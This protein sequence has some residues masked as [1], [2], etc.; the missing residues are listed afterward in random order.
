ML[1]S[2]KGVAIGLVLCVVAAAATARADDPAAA[3]ALFNEGKA[4]AAAGR[5]G[6]ACPR[7]E[8]SQRMAP[9]IGTRFNLADCQEHIG[10]TA[11]A[12][13]NFLGV[14]AAAKAAGQPDREAAA[15]DRA[16]R[17]E[18]RLSRL[19]ILVP[20]ASRLTGL[21]VQRDGQ[22]LGAA[23]WGEAVP[24][25]PGT[26]AVVAKA[27]GKR[28]YEVDVDV[29]GEGATAR[30][31]IPALQD[32]PATAPPAPAVAPQPECPA[33]HPAP[34]APVIVNGT[35]ST[36]PIGWGLVIGGGVA[37]VGGVVFWLLRDG[38]VSALDGECQGNVCPPTAT[39]D[40]ATGKMYSG[41]SVTLF[42][43]GAAAAAAGAGLL[44]F[45]G[46]PAESSARVVPTAR[47]LD[48][49]GAF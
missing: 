44:L 4:L 19:A 23:Q 41:I 16:N 13:A 33:A 32:V 21:A 14:A 3:Q 5:Y 17:L 10:K 9:A 46:G 38:R 47:G 20:D 35:S 1:R 22:E 15:R 34:P 40:I 11:S 31:S 18:P 45:G 42:G 37:L 48:V 6:D 28:D 7:F 8:E 29:Q 30:V 26:H 25:D 43:L 12:W 2:V 36:K 49:V 27:A 24:V 39:S